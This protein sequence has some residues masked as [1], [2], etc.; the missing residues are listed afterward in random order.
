[1]VGITFGVV[2]A[3]VAVVL[4]LLALIISRRHRHVNSAS[5]QA[6]KEEVPER[7]SCDE[8]LSDVVSGCGGGSSEDIWTSLPFDH[9]IRPG[10]E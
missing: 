5:T 6:F 1:V 9:E 2:I 3:I 10:N 4:A 8:E 7:V